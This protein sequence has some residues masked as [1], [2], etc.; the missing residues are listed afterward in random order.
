MTYAL[1]IVQ[2]LLAALFLFGGTVKLAMPIEELTA[3]VPVPG[4]FIQFISVAEILGAF[5]L[6]LP[7]LLR[8]RPVLTPLAAAGL[9]IIMAGATAL[10]LASGD[11]AA[12]LFPLVTGLFALLVAYGRCRL[13]SIRQSSRRAMLQTTS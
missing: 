12:T 5:G 6:V 4:L 8:I 13:A 3:Q 11:A 1:W 7:A 9:A 10:G 2:G